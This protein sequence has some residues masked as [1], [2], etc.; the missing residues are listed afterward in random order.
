MQKDM[1]IRVSLNPEERAELTEAVRASGLTM[2]DLLRVAYF[3]WERVKVTPRPTAD[4]VA[5]AQVI[6]QL[7]R[8]GNNLNQIA[9]AIHS[10]H[11]PPSA[12]IAAGLTGIHEQLSD[13]SVQVRH[14]LGIRWDQNKEINK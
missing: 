5:L 4:R 13:I 6:G 9:H 3:G 7:G 14:A 12:E 2:S 10:A 8:Q 11:I 1:R